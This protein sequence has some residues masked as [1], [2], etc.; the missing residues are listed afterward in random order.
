MSILEKY[1]QKQKFYRIQLLLQKYNSLNDLLYYEKL[2]EFELEYLIRNFELNQGNWLYISR[3]QKLS[4]YFIEKHLDKV[5]WWEIS[6]YQTL[7]EE[8]IEKHEDKIRW[9]AVFCN[10]ILSDEF[11]EKHKCKVNH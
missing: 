2:L 7:S 10:Q 9:F 4:E 8:F 3:F 1:K 5:N 6:C 11:K